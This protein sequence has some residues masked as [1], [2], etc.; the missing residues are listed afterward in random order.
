MDT[1][2]G[3]GPKIRIRIRNADTE[4]GLD[5]KKWSVNAEQGHKMQNHSIRI[6]NRNDHVSLRGKTWRETELMNLGAY[7]FE[8]G[9]SGRSEGTFTFVERETRVCISIVVFLLVFS[10]V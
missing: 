4:Y 5:P 8:E 7:G 3:V 9:P 2:Y 6:V 1:E 10:K